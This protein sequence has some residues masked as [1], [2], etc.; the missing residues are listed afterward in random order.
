MGVRT[1]GVLTVRSPCPVH[2]LDDAVARSSTVGWLLAGGKV[3]P[4]A[5]RELGGGTEQ[6]GGGRGSLESWVDGEGGWRRRLDG[7]P[8][9]RRSPMAGGSGGEVRQLEEGKGKMRQSSSERKMAAQ[10]RSPRG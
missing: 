9:Q 4:R 2:V 3:S 8:R 6:G 7:L 10:R 1:R 5:R